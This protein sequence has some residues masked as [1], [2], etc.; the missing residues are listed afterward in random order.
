MPSDLLPRAYSA[1]GETE[2]VGALG[3]VGAAAVFVGWKLA[4]GV[5]L[6]LEALEELLARRVGAGAPVFRAAP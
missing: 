4:F 6:A 1:L 2:H 3:V 5:D